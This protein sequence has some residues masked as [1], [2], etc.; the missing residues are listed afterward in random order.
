MEQDISLRWLST[1]AADGSRYE[2]MID[3]FFNGLLVDTAVAKT[4]AGNDLRNA[5]GRRQQQLAPLL[6]AADRPALIVHG[7]SADFFA[8]LF[9]VW[10][11]G[12]CAACVSPD[13]TPSQLETVAEFLRPAVV[14]A[15]SSQHLPNYIAGAPILRLQEEATEDGALRS[16][17]PPANRPAL[18]L[19]TSG[20][21]G[22]PKGVVH[23]FAS[24]AAR[25]DLNL[26]H[27]PAADLART[28][29]G[30]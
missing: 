16:A 11:L 13:L 3:R 19:F 14:L 21:T 5:V 27:I 6:S 9:A 25:I 29:C 8:A 18:I 22:N 4:L 15:A 28:L 7:G 10:G 26:Q 20:T 1:E 2:S 23:T 30:L 12:G 24:L 17:S